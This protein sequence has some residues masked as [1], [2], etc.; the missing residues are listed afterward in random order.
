LR[1]LLARL[2]E[3]VQSNGSSESVFSA[4]RGHALSIESLSGVPFLAIS[5]R[6][7]PR[8]LVPLTAVA[9]LEL[10]PEAPE[11]GDRVVELAPKRRER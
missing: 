10:E 8:V 1:I 5:P 7:G 6:S 11:A 2:R 4:E 9:S 3:R